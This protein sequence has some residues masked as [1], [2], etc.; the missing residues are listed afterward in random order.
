MSTVGLV[1]H[2]IVLVQRGVGTVL[3]CARNRMHREEKQKA[4]VRRAH[5]SND[6]LSTTTPTRTP[7]CG[8]LPQ[9][10]TLTGKGDLILHEGALHIQPPPSI[11]PLSR[12]GSATPPP[13]GTAWGTAHPPRALTVSGGSLDVSG[14]GAAVRSTRANSPALLVSVGLLD[15]DFEGEKGDDVLPGNGVDGMGGVGEESGF[16][17]SGVALA[18]NVRE[19][20]QGGEGEERKIQEKGRAFSWLVVVGL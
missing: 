20:S 18:V 6:S 8:A 17:Y 2:Q 1:L 19:T 11:Y 4:K 10:L 7:A 3:S 5:H 12:A 15:Q 13:T 9:A 14:G 16:A